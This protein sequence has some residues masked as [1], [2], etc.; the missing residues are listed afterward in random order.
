MFL[1]LFEVCRSPLP[2]VYVIDNT[3]ESCMFNLPV[4][5]RE[6]VPN[7]CT[8]SSDTAVCCDPPVLVI[9]I[10]LRIFVSS[11]EETISE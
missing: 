6:C 1:Q 11:N 9:R 5:D 2:F 8:E 4:S 7:L 10:V 3:S